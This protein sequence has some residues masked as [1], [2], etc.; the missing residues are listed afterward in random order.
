MRAELLSQ[1]IQS[2]RAGIDMAVVLF[3]SLYE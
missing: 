2:K 1:P 3:H